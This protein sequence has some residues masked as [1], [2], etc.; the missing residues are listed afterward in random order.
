MTG[1]E[2]PGAGPSAVAGEAALPGGGLPGPGGGR[3]RGERRRRAHGA[4]AACCWREGVGRS[5]RALRGGPEGLVLRSGGAGARG[6]P[7]K[8]SPGGSSGAAGVGFRAASAPLS[9]PGTL[10]WRGGSWWGLQWRRWA[11]RCFL[12]PLRIFVCLRAP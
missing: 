12:E 4:V 8:G 2:G 3:G 5:Q 10:G 9:L 11:L 6:S 1:G 7:G